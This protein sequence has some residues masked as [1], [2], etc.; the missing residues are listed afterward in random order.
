MNGL[1]DPKNA[2]GPGEL[3]LPEMRARTALVVA[4]DGYP[5]CVVSIFMRR[6]RHQSVCRRAHS[7][8]YGDQ[9]QR[10]QSQASVSAHTARYPWSAPAPFTHATIRL[11]DRPRACSGLPV[12][13]RCPPIHCNEATRQRHSFRP[14]TTPSLVRY[15]ASA[16]LHSARQDSAV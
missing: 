12:P 9:S 14:T 5:L 2:S 1:A 3:G 4:S 10:H 15:V 11:P 8:E 13:Q 16:R 6:Y 7:P